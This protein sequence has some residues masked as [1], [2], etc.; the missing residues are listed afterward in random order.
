[1]TQSSRFVICYPGGSG[2]SFLAAALDAAIFNRG[3]FIDKT[4][5]HCHNNSNGKYTRF[6]KHGS[7]LCSFREEL[8]AIDAMEFATVTQG[9]YRNIVALKEKIV[10]TYGFD[11]GENTTFIK[12]IVDSANSKEILFVANMLQRKMNCFS[13]LIFDEYLIQTTNYIKSWYWI[14]NA[15]T[16]PQTLTL[17]LSDVFLNNISNKLRLSEQSAI[18]VDQYQ[19]EYLTVQKQL[20]SDLLTLLH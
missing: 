6:F 4:L 3:F 20:H 5:G 2:G 11:E 13:D 17:T 16:I 7:T 9:H 14:E 8:D 19:N 10:N 12:I 18:K 1:M 15:Y